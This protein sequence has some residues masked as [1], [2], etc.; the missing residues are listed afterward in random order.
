MQAKYLFFFRAVLFETLLFQVIYAPLEAPG[1]YIWLAIGLYAF[2]VPAW[3]I[4]C[5]KREIPQAWNLWSF[6]VDIGAT[7]IIFYLTQGIASEFYIAYF[8]VILASCFLDSLVY[9]F[10]V[11]GV[12]CIVYGTL[13]F[14]GQEAF[15]QAQHLMR[16]SLLLTTSFFSSYMVDGAR[17]AASVVEGRY[18]DQIAWLQRLT[19][20]GRALTGILH[21]VRTPLGTIILTA[22]RIRYLIKRG[23]HHIIEEQLRII[24]QESQRSV[25]IL[26]NF[27]EYTKPTD[28]QL[29]PVSLCPL[30]QAAL[31]A[32]KIRIEERGV[33]LNCDLDPELRVLGSGRH[34]IQVFTNLFMNAIHAMPMGGKLSVSARDDGSLVKIEVSDTGAG[35]EPEVMNH[36]FEPFV[37]SH[38]SEGGHG[39]GLHIARWIVQKHNG[40]ILIESEGPGKGAR[41]TV[42]LPLAPKS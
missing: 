32:M 3:Y 42:T 8:L 9:S 14:P 18:R 30:V 27:L 37:S 10:I 16:L 26:S 6:T 23:D 28:L 38:L 36:L 22:D 15:L 4:A 40:E 21:E 34:L 7:S 11:G 12:A 24:D 17:R 41:I 33:I 35:I 29:N 20:V 1:W 19:L 2:F 25:D 5:L 39:L 13:A 31:D